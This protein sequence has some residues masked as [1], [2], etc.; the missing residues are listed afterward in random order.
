VQIQNKDLTA[1]KRTIFPAAV[2]GKEKD[3]NRL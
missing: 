1:L 3:E 2:A